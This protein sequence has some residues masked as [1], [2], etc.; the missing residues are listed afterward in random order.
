MKKFLESTLGLGLITALTAAVL[1]AC[2]GGELKQIDFTNPTPAPTPT[3][4]GGTN[5]PAP[6]A[7]D[8]DPIPEAGVDFDCIPADPLDGQQ[9]KVK[10]SSVDGQ[11]SGDGIYSVGLADVTYSFGVQGSFAAVSSNYSTFVPSPSAG[12]YSLNGNVVDEVFPVFV[13]DPDPDE[14]FNRAPSII[15]YSPSDWMQR[16]TKRAELAE[17]GG[18]Y[19]TSVTLEAKGKLPY[20]LAT[21]YVDPVVDGPNA[22]IQAFF[23]A[24]I[25]R[26]ANGQVGTVANACNYSV[27]LTRPNVGQS[28]DNALASYKLNGLDLEP[29]YAILAE[30]HTLEPYMPMLQGTFSTSSAVPFVPVRSELAHTY[31]VSSPAAAVSVTTDKGSTIPEKALTPESP[32]ASQT[33]TFDSVQ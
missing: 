14:V 28:E 26:L 27:T 8:V 2:G 31:G 20:L 11:G 3:G 16:A 25:T 21:L 12:V 1:V 19:T 17:V 30:R 13:P 33:M 4:S 23:T 22:A 7:Q 5:D 32:A 18:V 10:V 15:T 6:P 9:I 24:T 29:V